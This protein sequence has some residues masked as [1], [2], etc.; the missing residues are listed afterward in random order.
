VFLLVVVTHRLADIDALRPALVHCDKCTGGKA[1]VWRA[2][3]V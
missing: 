1:T 2:S 3:M